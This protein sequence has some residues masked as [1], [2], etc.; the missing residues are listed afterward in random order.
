M[1]LTDIIALA[2]AG[3]K[4]AD[5]KEL[6]SLSTDN[7]TLNETKPTESLAEE[8]PQVSEAQNATMQP[9]VEEKPTIDYK[10]LYEQAQSELKKAQQNNI[11][12]NVSSEVNEKSD[13]DILNEITSSFM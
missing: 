1:N 11:R 6:V 13:L 3:Y 5:I 9:E 2:K 4:P 8:V 7:A 12:Q 10:A